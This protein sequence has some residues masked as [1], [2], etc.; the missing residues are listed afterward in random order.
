ME[1]GERDQPLVHARGFERPF[2]VMP[3]HRQLDGQ[4]YR[5]LV[6]EPIHFRQQ[7]GRRMRPVARGGVEEDPDS[8]PIASAS[9]SVG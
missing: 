3:R 2:R 6:I 5:T 8:F 1:A 7:I 4:Q 9:A